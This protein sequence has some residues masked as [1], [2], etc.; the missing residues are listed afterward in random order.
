VQKK[1]LPQKV[2]AIAWKDLRLRFTGKTELLFFLILPLVFTLLLSGILFGGEGSSKI[3]VVVVDEDNS[4]LSGELVRLLT[5]S[6]TVAPELMARADGQ[7]TFNDRNA[8]AILII[9][10]GMEASLKTGQPVALEFSLDPS[11]NN[12]F[13]VQQEVERAVGQVS[14]SLAVASA[15]LREAEQILPFA[16]A[17]ARQV[18]YDQ[19]LAAAQQEF[20][21]APT[22]I[23]I[24]TPETVAD[25]QNQ[26][27]AQAAQASAGQLIIW[28][29][30]P[31]LGT[32]EL[33][34]Y[35]RVWGT[36]RRLVTTPTRKA[37]FLTGIITG[38]LSSGLLQMF[39]LVVIGVVL[40]K[41]PWGNN[42]PALMLLL[43]SFGLSAVAL[44]TMLGTFT[45]TPSQ[46]NGLS[47]GLG[48]VMGL[49]GGC[50]WPIE[51]FPPAVANA[52]KVLPTTWAMA[53]MTQLTVYDAGMAE[54]LPYAAV[55]LGF[56]AVF[57]VVGVWRFRYE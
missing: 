51:L 16:D 4:A 30:I 27:A 38:Q 10:D 15:S 14:R 40:L 50:M 23:V 35:E 53:G 48:M 12:G 33:L 28:V 11:N 20:T 32:S 19:S 1:Y 17:E 52:A 41:V 31:L 18:Y 8:A 5:D 42:P 37:T 44:G 45:R 49:L 26:K 55:L 29:F 2:F 21:S 25:F 3:V 24:T 6:E 13:A 36:L 34:A 22:R 43:V 54:I 57:F 56:A 9:P 46:A 47:I 7:E 39:M